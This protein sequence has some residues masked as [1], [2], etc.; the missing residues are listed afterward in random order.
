MNRDLH[1]NKLFNTLKAAKQEEPDEYFINQMEFLAL[2]TMLSKTGRIYK[3]L[4]RMAVCLIGILCINLAAYSV[5][6]HSRIKPRQACT[7]KLEQ[8][9]YYLPVKNLY[10]EPA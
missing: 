8:K 4:L 7:Q 6:A 3:S 2:R 1:L 9:A 5:L 10:D